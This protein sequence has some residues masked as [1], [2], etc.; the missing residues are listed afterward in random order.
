MGALPILVPLILLALYFVVRPRIRTSALGS[1]FLRK[2]WKLAKSAQDTDISVLQAISGT[3]VLRQECP[4]VF[5]TTFNALEKPGRTDVRT[6]RGS[7]DWP[8]GLDPWTLWFQH[9]DA[10]DERSGS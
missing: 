10:D 2:L 3:D 5:F 1:R 8:Q 9:E 6:Y 4:D 7:T